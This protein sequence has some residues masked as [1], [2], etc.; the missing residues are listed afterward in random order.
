MLASGVEVLAEFRIVGVQ[1]L[2]VAARKI[3]FKKA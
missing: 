2:L 3:F 1:A